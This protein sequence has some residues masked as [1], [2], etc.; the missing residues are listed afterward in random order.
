MSRATVLIVDDHDL[1]GLSLQVLLRSHGVETARC[2]VDE[3]SVLQTA[4]QR[5]PGLAL[6]DLDLGPR[7]DGERYRGAELI[8]GLRNAGWPV[9]VFTGTA[10]GH[11]AALSDAIAAGAL[12]WLSKSLPA[13]EVVHEI[14]A[15]MNG[16]TMMSADERHELMEERRGAQLRDHATRELLDRLTA[17]EQLVLDRLIA[18]R[19]AS[20]IA[21]E[22]S[23]SMSTVRTQIHAILAKL[24][25]RSQL[26]AVALVRALRTNHRDG[27]RP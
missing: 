3:K 20:A 11:R 22:F 14:L 18:G 6:V 23:V 17:R 15:A 25:V 2:G 10:D 19:R 8:P 16:K 9:L 13:Q 27:R 21:R 26:E 24:N 5:D 4:Y 1:I 12:G 7:P